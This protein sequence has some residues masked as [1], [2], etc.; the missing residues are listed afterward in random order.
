MFVTYVDKMFTK[1]L[2]NIIFVIISQFTISRL[3]TNLV[4]NITAQNLVFYSEQ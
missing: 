3:Q 4:T 1:V 2:L